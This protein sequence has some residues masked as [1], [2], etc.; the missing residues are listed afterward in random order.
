[1]FLSVVWLLKWRRGK[2]KMELLKVYHACNNIYLLRILSWK[3]IISIV[4]K[5]W[6]NGNDN[7]NGDWLVC[8]HMTPIKCNV[9]QCFSK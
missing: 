5:Q 6:R 4:M 1:M 2:S 7:G 8:G 9:A 3:D